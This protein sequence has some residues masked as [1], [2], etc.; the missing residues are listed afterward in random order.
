MRST[1]WVLAGAAAFVAAALVFA[2][3]QRGYEPGREAK[4]AAPEPRPTGIEKA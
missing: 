4:P 3:P 2:P 1:L